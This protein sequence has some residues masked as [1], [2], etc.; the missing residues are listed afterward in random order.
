MDQLKSFNSPN[1]N[2][3]ISSLLSFF[4]NIKSI[5]DNIETLRVELC[6]QPEFYPKQ[7][8]QYLDAKN[9]DFLLLDDFVI[10][11]QEM[12]IP[13]EEKYLRKFI[14]NFDK[15][16]DFCLNFKEFLGLI[17]PK[18]NIELSNRVSL[19]ANKN[20]EQIIINR[21]I[22]NIF[23][24]ILCEE[25]ELV[26]N[27]IKTAKFCRATIGFTFY[28]GFIAIAGNEK[29]IT[30]KHL[31]NFLVQNKINISAYDMHQLMFRLDA[32]NDGN[33]SFTEFQE[34][35]FP[36]KE[37]EIIARNNAPKQDNYNFYTISDVTTQRRK[38]ELLKKI[39]QKE[40]VS[41][42][43]DQN[44]NILSIPNMNSNNDIFEKENSFNYRNNSISSDSKASLYND[45]SMYSKSESKIK[46]YN[47][48][49]A[50][51]IEPK[52]FSQ[53]YSNFNDIPNNDYSRTYRK[54]T[55]A[56]PLESYQSRNDS[57]SINSPEVLHAKSPLNY[58]YSSYS[59]EDRDVLFR[60]I[61]KTDNNRNFRNYR[62]DALMNR[63]E[64][65]N[66]NSIYNNIENKKYSYNNNSIIN[67]IETKK[68][69]FKS[70][71]STNNIYSEN[72]NSNYQS[73]KSTMKPCCGCSIYDDLCPC[74]IS[75]KY[76]DNCSCPNKLNINNKISNNINH[77][78]S[79]NSSFY[80][81]NYN[82]SFKEEAK[83][84]NNDFDSSLNPKL[85]RSKSQ[86]NFTY[87]NDIGIEKLISVRRFDESR[88]Y[89]HNK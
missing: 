30:E 48:L 60:Q 78:I 26:K 1:S 72:K 49:T 31:Y 32:D 63:I 42:V 73:N 46:T 56:S 58:D 19:N 22:K 43:Q 65:K 13:Y 11:L 64:N 8:F 66:N 74:P 28:E 62:D 50:P 29:Y 67:N 59:N 27:C 21:N 84:N 71:N 81:S 86:F 70:S 15:D 76:P 87:N 24:K 33:I 16:N 69:R 77:N 40:D 61:P 83:N 9:K 5:D 38:I 14:H 57:T 7:F 52:N 89:S 53:D 35:F 51:L 47:E 85:F 79:N 80:K 36:M 2:E 23:G 54:S 39:A 88:L 44:V 18:K 45:K 41:F 55:L 34:I 68:Y 4:I 17:L 6:S 12:H 82:R 75:C 20:F 25:L 37:G 10:F 3:W